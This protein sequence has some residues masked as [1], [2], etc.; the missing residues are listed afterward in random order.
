MYA[1]GSPFS[2]R[3]VDTFAR[4]DEM[5]FIRMRWA[6]R[7]LVLTSNELNMLFYSEAV[8]VVGVKSLPRRLNSLGDRGAEQAELGGHQAKRQ[9]VL[10]VVFGDLGHL[11][12]EA[13]IVLVMPQDAFH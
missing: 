7:A 13:R 9:I 6:T 1:C 12:F 11:V 10:G 8:Y 5:A 4:F 3:V 2:L